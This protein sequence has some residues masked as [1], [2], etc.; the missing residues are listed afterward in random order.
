MCNAWGKFTQDG[1]SYSE[2]RRLT[3]I[4]DRPEFIKYGHLRNYWKC[5]ASHGFVIKTFCL[6]QKIHVP[7]FLRMQS[8]FCSVLGK[9]NDN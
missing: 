4:N 2:D 1:E 8:T 5:N 7:I 6:S 9:K 3:N